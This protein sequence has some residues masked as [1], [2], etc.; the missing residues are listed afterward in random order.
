MKKDKKASSETIPV[1]VLPPKEKAG[2]CV[3][4]RCCGYC[5]CG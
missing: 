4:G 1:I 3:C 2:V 5:C